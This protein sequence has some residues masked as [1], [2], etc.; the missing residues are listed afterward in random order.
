MSMIVTDTVIARGHN[1]VMSTHKTTLEITKDNDLT[2]RGDCIIGVGASKG[3]ADLS[4]KFKEA[5]K[6]LDARIKILIEVGELREVIVAK[7]T[8]QLS[9]THTT[10]LVVR[11]SNYVCKRTVAIGADKAAC[12]LSRMFVNKLQNPNQRIKVT[13]S[14][15]SKVLDDFNNSNDKDGS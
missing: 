12:D 5:A 7:G 4:S 9:F 6:Q 3:A 11:K 13:L 2:K 10:D 1:N 14:V 8:P 15:E